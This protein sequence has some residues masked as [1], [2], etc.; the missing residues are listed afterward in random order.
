MKIRTDFVTN[1]SSSSFVAVIATKKNG[2]VVR[3]TLD[4]GT[5]YYEIPLIEGSLDENMDLFKDAIQGSKDAFDFCDKLYSELLNIYHTAHDNLYPIREMETFEELEAIQIKGEQSGSSYGHFD[6]TYNFSTQEVSGNMDYKGGYE[7]PEGRG[8]IEKRCNY[9]GELDRE[10]TFE[11]VD[12]ILKK[13]NG[14]E[15]DIIVPEGVVG[16]GV[17]AF[18]LNSEIENVYLPDTVKYIDAL[19]FFHCSRLKR[20]NLPNGLE[21]LG[22]S[23]FAGCSSIKKLELPDSLFELDI[24]CFK[25][26]KDLKEIEIPSGVTEIPFEAFGSCEKLERILLPTG[27]EKIDEYAFGWCYGLREIRFPEGLRELN[28]KAM[29]CCDNIERVYL[30][31]TVDDACASA[32]NDLKHLEAIFVDENNKHYKSI[33]GVLYTKDL[34]RLIKYPRAKKEAEYKIPT[35]VKYISEYAFMEAKEL[36]TLSLPQGLERIGIDAFSCCKGIDRIELPDS[37]K[38][39]S[40]G[41]FEGCN[42]LD[43]IVIP[44]DFQ[45]D[46]ES[47]DYWRE[48]MKITKR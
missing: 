20:I 14:H 2:E 36:E 4:C 27:I 48:D 3:G 18:S 8:F 26:M 7:E 34:K 13:Y 28:V 40:H 37:I 41:A 24:E 1:S 47:Y 23:A 39:V 35:G 22:K 45:L 33:D 46:E 29:C 6:Y 44:K 19:G 9:K 38:S 42:S 10:G 17:C 11:I 25:E 21:R 16:I 30:P 12:G 32:F 5:D 43:E 15:S 31:S